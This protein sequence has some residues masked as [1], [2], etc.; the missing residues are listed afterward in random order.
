MALSWFAD[1]QA[2][3]ESFT[4]W[5]RESELNSHLWSSLKNQFWFWTSAGISTKPWSFRARIR[6]LGQPLCQW[7]TTRAEIA[8]PREPEK[9]IGNFGMWASCS[10]QQERQLDS[11]VSRQIH[12]LCRNIWIFQERL[13]NGFYYFITR[14][15][16]TE[17]YPILNNDN[18]FVCTLGSIS[19]LL[20]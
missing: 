7:E 19:N 10:A 13:Q 8:P 9:Q 17:N 11:W 14:G 15:N 4:T 6:E 16:C 5:I 3:H 18:L 12:G 20:S 1:Y 2:K